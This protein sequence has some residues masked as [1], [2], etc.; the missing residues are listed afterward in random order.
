MADNKCV[1]TGAV[2]ALLSMTFTRFLCYLLFAIGVWTA[3]EEKVLNRGTAP[4]DRGATSSLKLTTRTRR[5]KDQEAAPSTSCDDRGITPL[6]DLLTSLTF[7]I[8]PRRTAS[9]L[10]SNT[11]ACCLESSRKFQHEILHSFTAVI[12][13]CYSTNNN[14]HTIARPRN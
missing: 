5:R 7:Q 11:T 1:K 10:D 9:A 4:K 14:L 2:P 8:I 3:R 12:G 13:G 6:S